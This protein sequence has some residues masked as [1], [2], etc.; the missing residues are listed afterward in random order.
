M[1]PQSSSWRQLSRGKCSRRGVSL[2]YVAIALAALCGLTSLAV[3]VGRVLLVKAELRQAAD[4]AARHAAHGL[5]QYDVATA[6]AYAV[7]CADDN[8]ADGTPVAL[9]AQQDVDFGTWNASTRRFTQLHGVNLASANAV[10]VTARRTAA[11]NSAVRLYFAPLVGFPTAD[12][13]VTAVARVNARLPSL[14]G[15][16]SIT[17]SGS[18]NGGGNQTNSYR[19][20]DGPLAPGATYYS[21]GTLASNGNI[22]LSGNS[23]INGDVRPGVNGTAS[24]S[25]GATVTGTVAP[26]SKPLDYPMESAGQAATVNNNASVPS[27]YLSSGRDFSLGGAT[28]TLA[29]GTYYWDDVNIGSSGTLVFTGPATVYVTGS[30][31]IDGECRSYSDLPRNLR[32]V[33]VNTGTTFECYSGGVTYADV[34]APGSTFKMA[35][36]ATLCGSVIART[37]EMSGTARLVFDESMTV[38]S[39]GVSLVG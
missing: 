15:L 38:T 30:V 22:A 10:R 21:R 39:P 18:A 37:V 17:M 29:G 26:L 14:V 25:G 36:S 34:Y 6:R 9:H 20:N 13:T 2:V 27:S 1:R 11:R 8:T 16:D 23:T 7:D 12:V 19:S 3:D 31:K 24:I 32:F 33:L 35:G 5:A 28:L 4:A